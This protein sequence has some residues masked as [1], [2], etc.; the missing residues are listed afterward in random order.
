MTNDTEFKGW[1]VK[2]L[3]THPTFIIRIKMLYS[4]LCSKIKCKQTRQSKTFRE[5]CGCVCVCLRLQ[6]LLISDN[7]MVLFTTKKLLRGQNFQ[8][9][10]QRVLQPS[11]S[12]FREHSFN[13]QAMALCPMARKVTLVRTLVAATVSTDSTSLTTVVMT[14][15]GASA[16]GRV[17][18]AVLTSSRPG[19]DDN[20]T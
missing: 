19:I 12:L 3:L 14:T 10:T 9:F 17:D 8:T 2:L 6:I 7:V 16:T 4:Y 18:G 11:P 13:T 5:S 1:V 20:Y 15:N